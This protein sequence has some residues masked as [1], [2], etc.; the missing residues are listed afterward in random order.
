MSGFG[1]S[2]CKFIMSDTVQGTIFGL[3][4]TGANLYNI[5]LKKHQDTDA[6][7]RYGTVSCAKGFFYGTLYPF[8][9]AFVVVQA[10]IADSADF[11]SHF[12]PLSKAGDPKFHLEKKECDIKKGRI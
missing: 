8:S 2:L 3:T 7:M 5:R 11:R 12:I 10:F 9:A 6:L 4:I 1:Q